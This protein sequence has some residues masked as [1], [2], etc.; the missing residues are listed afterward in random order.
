[1][2]SSL[3]RGNDL[4]RTREGLSGEVMF[5]EDGGGKLGHSRTDEENLVKNLCGFEGSLFVCRLGGMTKLSHVAEE[6]DE[7]SEGEF[8]LRSWLVGGWVAD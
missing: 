7:A 8:G 3:K 6:G 4:P 5:V 1:M 2:K